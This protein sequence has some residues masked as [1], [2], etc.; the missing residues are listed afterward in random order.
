MVQQQ[1]HSE[2]S[3]GGGGGMGNNNANSVGALIALKRNHVMAAG[4]A[5]AAAAANAGV[6]VHQQQTSSLGAHAQQQQ[7]LHP[8]IIY[9][10]MPTDYSGN[11]E[12]GDECGNGGVGDA[13]R[14]KYISEVLWWVQ[15]TTASCCPSTVSTSYAGSFADTNDTI[16]VGN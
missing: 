12:S 10:E 11:M 14:P 3:G 4:A 15:Q 6:V 5:A 13:K 1:Q 8:D 16:A 7:N 2:N 9:E